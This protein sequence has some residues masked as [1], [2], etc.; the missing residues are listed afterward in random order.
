MSKLFIPVGLP[1]CGKSTFAKLLD[2]IR[3]RLTGDAGIQTSNDQVFAEYHSYIEHWLRYD[4]IYADATNLR[5]YAR[6]NLYK[7]ADRVQYADRVPVETHVLVFTNTV[8]AVERNL[9]RERVVP[10]DVM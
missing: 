4:N 8:Q 10:P 6:E 7:I 5:D 9:K 3:E 1:G 2:A